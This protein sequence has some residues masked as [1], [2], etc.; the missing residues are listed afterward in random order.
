MTQVRWYSNWSIG[1]LLSNGQE[2]GSG[3]EAF[4]KSHNFDPT[5]KITKVEVIIWHDEGGIL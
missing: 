3:T 5:K 2:C 1:F 4:N